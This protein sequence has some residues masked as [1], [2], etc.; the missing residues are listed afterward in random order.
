[1]FPHTITI[2]HHTASGG[3][4]VYT[5]KVVEGVYWHGSTGISRDGKGQ[6]STDSITVIS[7]PENASTYGRK[8]SV[9]KGDKVVK[10]ACGDISSFKELNSKEVITVMSVADNRCNSSVDNITIT[11]K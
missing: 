7:S 1:M 9:Q 4:D 5:R 6:E 10:G 11:G 2:F 3:E 8:W